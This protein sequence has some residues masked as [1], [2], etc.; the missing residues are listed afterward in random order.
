MNKYKASWTT[1]HEVNSTIQQ[2]K[3]KL[4][5]LQKTRNKELRNAKT[6]TEKAKVR[7][8]YDDEIKYYDYLLY[9]IN[10]EYYDIIGKL[11]NV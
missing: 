6:E 7:S 3:D 1:R 4:V 5:L 11:K 10:L 9:L 8:R 2:L